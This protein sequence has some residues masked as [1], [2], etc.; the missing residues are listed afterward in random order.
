MARGSITQLWTFAALLFL[1]PLRV[2]PASAEWVDWIADGEVESRFTDNLNDSAFS[3]DT[4]NDF[5]W[6]ATSRLGRTYQLTDHTRINLMAEISGNIFHEYFRLSSVRAGGRLELFHKFGLGNAPWVRTSFFG[7]Y[8]D[9][10][11]EVRSGRRLEVGLTAGKRFSP[12]LDAFVGYRF[13]ERDGG[14]GP[15]AVATITRGVFDQ[16]AHQIRVGANFLL[17]E[18]LL[19]SAGYTFRFGDFHSAC[20]VPNV[21]KVLAKE[22]VKAIIL[23][24]VFGGCVYRLRGTGHSASVNLN[25]GLTDRIS[26]DVGYRYDYGKADLLSYKTNVARVGVV[27]R[28]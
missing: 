8:E 4:E 10:R 3:Q 13:L 25:Y 21:G 26:L 1:L 5:S 2:A 11:H 16:Q 12:R 23:D 27:F 9:V 20:T 15:R 6:H 18:P 22:N 28:Y 7:G 24:R 17:L 19:L 14:A